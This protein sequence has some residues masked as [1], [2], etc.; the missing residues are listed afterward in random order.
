MLIKILLGKKC[1]NNGR[2][3]PNPD[4]VKSS[5]GC[6]PEGNEWLLSAGKILAPQF[7]RCC[8][9]HDICY[10]TCNLNN[11]KKC[12]DDFN[13][14]MM[15]LCNTIYSKSLLLLKKVACK[16]EGTLMYQAVKMFGKNA[17]IASQNL[18]CLCSSS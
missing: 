15:E 1:P 7:Q 14:C 6:G 8:N 10:D 11:K 4:Y 9:G 5:N 3:I 18:S 13:N 12:D 17:F 16:S 2:L